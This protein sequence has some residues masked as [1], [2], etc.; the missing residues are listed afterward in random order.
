MKHVYYVQRL[1]AP[2]VLTN[3][4]TSFGAGGKPNGG[5]TKEMMRQLKGVF[6]FDYMG[7]AEFEWG[8]VPTA[9]DKLARDVIATNTLQTLHHNVF[10]IA[11]EAIIAEVTEWVKNAAKGEHGALKERLMF[12]E[13]LNN[14]KYVETK[15]WLKIEND[16]MCKEPFMFFID[17]EMFKNTCKLLG[18]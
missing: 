9:L 2:T 3:T 11:P 8:A 12:K 17:E 18:I 16:D 4:T 14:E 6:T 15:G 13:A 10:I 7:A 5:M 1:N